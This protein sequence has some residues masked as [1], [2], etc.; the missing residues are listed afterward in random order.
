MRILIIS[1]LYPPFYLGGYELRC[2][3]TAD[4]I[5]R[6]GHEVYVL[7]S[8]WGLEKAQID[9]NIYRL[10]Y[11]NPNSDIIKRKNLSDPYRLRRR[12][13]QLKW[14]FL[15]RRNYNITCKLI[16]ALKPE[17]I[18]IWNMGSVGI[19]PILSAQ[20]IGVPIVYSLGIGWLIYLRNELNREPNLIKRKFRSAL[21]G[22][23]DFQIL[24]LRYMIAISH[25]LRNIYVQNGFPEQNITVIPRGIPS[26]KILNECDLKD[27]S[28]KDKIRLLFVGRICPEKAPDDAI[29]A[30]GI[31]Y[32]KAGN[33]DIELDIIGTGEEKYINDLKELVARF[34]L[35][36]HISFLGRL[37]PNETFNLYS[38]YDALLF[39][40]RWEEPLGVVVLEAMAQGLPVIATDRGGIP[41]IITDGLNGLLVPAN[42]PDKLAEAISRLSQEDGLPLRLK[43]AALKTIREQFTLEQIVDQ[44]IQYFQ[45]NTIGSSKTPDLL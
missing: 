3:E 15:C 20:F 18:F 25:A 24:D 13:G 37:E 16:I 10:L 40:S 9:G 41:E 33:R 36:S 43:T 44:I 39:P 35:E 12:I 23:K 8:W 14:V 30:I 26:N 29:K 31:L 21:I 27:L 45:N 11:T 34:T 28:N 2:K 22:L 6:R 1:D 17:V 7:T 42:N 19:N 5:A 4:E 38:A 32:G